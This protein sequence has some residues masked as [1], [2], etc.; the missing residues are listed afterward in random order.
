[1]SSA[2]FLDTGAIYALADRNDTDHEGV[3]AI[4][5][6]AERHFITH[7]L[8]LVETFSL[9]TK[10]L[11]KQAALQTVGALR[12]SSRVEIVPLVPD[13]LAAAWAR[14]RRFADKDWDWIDYTS[15]EVMERRRLSG[16]LS[17]DR[18]FAQAGFQLLV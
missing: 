4:Y 1:L 15:F 17:L 10:R 8:V 12:N 2:V 16:A 13:L 14:C 11:H 9:L 7:D 3:R 5:T 6:D 18:H